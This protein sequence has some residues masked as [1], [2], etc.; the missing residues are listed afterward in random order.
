MPELAPGQWL[1]TEHPLTREHLRGRIVLLD[2]WDYTCVNC[3]RTLPYVASWHRRYA[4]L[5]LVVV[6]V[7]APE[8]TFAR[9]HAQVARAVADH[10]VG[11]PVLLDNEYQTWERFAIKA[12][13]TKILVDADGYIRRTWQGEGGYGETERAI[14]ALLRQQQP[15]VRF[16]EPLAA[17]RPEDRSGAVCYRPTPEIYAGVRGGGLFGGGLGNPE[18]YATQGPVFYRM[19]DAEERQEGHF[20]L[21]GA[22]R[23][24]A[25]AVSFAGQTRGEVRVRYSGATANAVLSPSADPVETIL[26]LWPTAAEPAV[27]VRQDGRFLTANL[28]G[29]DGVVGEDGRSVLRVTRPRM[30]ELVRNAEFGT[31]E[32][33]LTFCATGQALYTLTFTGCAAPAG[34][35]RDRETYTTR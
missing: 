8:F 32:L 14:Q 13:P 19:P 20:Y 28:A 22:W 25:E 11:Y 29:A 9:H 10:G 21:A 33:A 4:A 2:F 12:W 35:G 18:G 15:E 3:V 30:Y 23:A 27:E 34:G 6:G 5:G 1:N 31:H 24:L 16:P 17:L 26:D 7:H